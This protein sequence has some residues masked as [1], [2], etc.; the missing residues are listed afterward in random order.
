[1]SEKKNQS[2]YDWELQFKKKNTEKKEKKYEEIYPK[3]KLDLSDKETKDFL[4]K[5]KLSNLPDE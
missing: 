1:L 4:E 3:K 5:W 2:F